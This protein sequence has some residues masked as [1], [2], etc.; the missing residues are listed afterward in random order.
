MV[1]SISKG[2]KTN[3]NILFAFTYVNA[4]KKRPKGDT[5]NQQGPPLGGCL[6]GTWLAGVTCTL[7]LDCE[8]IYGEDPLRENLSCIIYAIR[9]RLQIKHK[10][11]MRNWE[12]PDSPGSPSMFLQLW[13]SLLVRLFHLQTSTC[14][15]TSHTGQVW[16]EPAIC[17]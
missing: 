15:S 2:H 11:L 7:P 6:P 14:I 4:V 13:L 8:W 9:V 10:C 16:G 1:S 17:S 3:Y 5:S 12:A